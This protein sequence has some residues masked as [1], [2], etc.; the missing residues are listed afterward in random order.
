MNNAKK[1]Y[2][3]NRWGVTPIFT[4]V[5][6]SDYEWLKKYRWFLNAGYAYTNARD[7]IIGS[8][9]SN[10]GRVILKAPLDKVVDHI[11]GNKLDNRRENLRVVTALENYRNKHGY[12][13]DG[14]PVMLP[15]GAPRQSVAITKATHEAL[16]DFCKEQDRFILE[17]TET[18]VKLYI[19][20]VRSQTAKAA[21]TPSLLNSNRL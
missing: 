9:K 6:E 18:A 5:D 21:P 16:V 15:K 3:C 2:L 17:T 10:M 8:R 14:A 11:N 4:I 1:I 13:H 19:E 7:A 20:H 12:V